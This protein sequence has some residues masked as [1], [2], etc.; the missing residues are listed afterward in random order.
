MIIT[1][2]ITKLCLEFTF[3]PVVMRLLPMTEYVFSYKVLEL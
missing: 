1:H 3:H 2:A